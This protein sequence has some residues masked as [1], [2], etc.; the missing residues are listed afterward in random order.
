[1]EHRPAL[2]VLPTALGRS[3]STLLTLHADDREFVV[4]IVGLIVEPA[5]RRLLVP[6]LATGIGIDRVRKRGVCFL[7]VEQKNA[8]FASLAAQNV[9]APRLQWAELGNIHRHPSGLSLPSGGDLATARAA[10]GELPRSPCVLIGIVDP[11]PTGDILTMSVVHRD[12]IRHDAPW[13]FVDLPT[14]A[15]ATRDDI[16]SWWSLPITHQVM[17]R[18]GGSAPPTFER[19]GGMTLASHASPTSWS[20][21]PSRLATE[22]KGGPN[23]CWRPTAHV[24]KLSTGP[25]ALS[26]LAP[27]APHSRAPGAA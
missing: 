7:D 3:I 11:R 16:A 4:G 15:D 13:T 6:L 20:I 8:L 25:E 27:P 19:N 2:V 23:G 1:M 21:Q 12:G 18:A 22:E 17:Q 14:L 9:Y 10:L 24:S 5:E 26:S